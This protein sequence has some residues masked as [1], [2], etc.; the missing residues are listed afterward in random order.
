[1]LYHTQRV[2]VVLTSLVIWLGSEIELVRLE[3]TVHVRKVVLVCEEI[4]Y[5]P[6]KVLSRLT[7]ARVASS[8]NE[9]E[10]RFQ[11][12]SQS[13]P[14]ELEPDTKHLFNAVLN[15]IMLNPRSWSQLDLLQSL[16]GLR[17]GPLSTVI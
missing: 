7:I 1:M 16:F 17:R 3:V 13:I 9:V 14:V 2:S 12:D 8:E 6:I 10:H 15:T 4:S 11:S 5:G